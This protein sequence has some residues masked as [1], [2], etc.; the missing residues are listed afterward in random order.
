[1]KKTIQE[2]SSDIVRINWPVGSHKNPKSP[3]LICFRPVY[4]ILFSKIRKLPA[5][6]RRQTAKIACSR[7]KSRNKR[8]PRKNVPAPRQI[9][10]RADRGGVCAFGDI[11]N[12]LMKFSL[13]PQ[14]NSPQ[15]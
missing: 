15:K 14:P 9:R 12:F 7:R 8:L 6:F 10:L 2:T 1:M 4:A 13:P 5:A 11:G 3:H